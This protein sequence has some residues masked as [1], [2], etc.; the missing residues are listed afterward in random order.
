MKEEAA[1]NDAVKYINKN[2]LNIKSAAK[3]AEKHNMDPC[4]FHYHFTNNFNVT[5]RLYIYEK[6][7]RKLEKLLRIY[8]DSGFDSLFYADALGFSPRAF[9]T[10]LKIMTNQSFE[11]FIENFEG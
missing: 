11:E 4:S 1:V 2:F 8:G 3:V 10:F 6:K 5:P 7:M 9:E